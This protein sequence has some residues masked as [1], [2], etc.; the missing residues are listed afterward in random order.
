[1]EPVF[2]PSLIQ[3]DMLH[4]A[5]QMKVINRYCH[6]LHMDVMDGHFAKNLAI[7]PPFIK[8]VRS[9]TD[10]PIDAHLMVSAPNEFLV[11]SMMEAGADILSL[12][13]E[14]I[15]VDAYRTL[16]KIHAAGKQFG[17]VLCTA[18]PLSFIETYIEKADMLTIM[19]VDV[20]YAGQ[21]F[22][23]EMLGKI[24]QAAELREKKGYTYRIQVDGNV[25]K[26][27]YRQLWDAGADTFVVGSAS[28]F[29]KGRSIEE[30]AVNMH[31]DFYE[32]TGVKPSI[33]E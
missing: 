6:M 12:H 23:P 5:D 26:A 18:T 29:V 24:E 4:V 28:M 31:K 13:A 19:T 30:N 3:M 32:E 20:G 27:V 17:V 1:M 15:A 11:D 2:S 25:G 22:I 16:N 10:L 33:N 7:N 8:A 9:V 14:T 21:K